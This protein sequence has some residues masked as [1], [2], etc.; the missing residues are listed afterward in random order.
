MEK[1]KRKKQ[2]E[3]T[4]FYPKSPYASSKLFSYWITKII[5]SHMVFLLVTEYYLTMNLKTW[6]NFCNKKDNYGS[7]KI[8]H[9]KENVYI[10]EIYMRKEIGVMQK[11]MLRCVGKFYNIK[12]L[13]IL[14]LQ[15]RNNIL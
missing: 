1:Y 10:W 7:C 13:M 4:R 12:N 3:K 2:S 15:Q 11:I 9:G 5:E 8:I 14:W 6:R